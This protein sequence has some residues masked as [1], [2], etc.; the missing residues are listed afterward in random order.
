V[1][2]DSG[3]QLIGMSPKSQAS[4]KLLRLS[5]SERFEHPL[6]VPLRVENSGELSFIGPNL[7]RAWLHALFFKVGFLLS[8]INRPKLG[9]VSD[10]LRA[11]N[12]AGVTVCNRDRDR[13]SGFP[14]CLTL[15]CDP[16]SN[17]NFHRLILLCRS[18]PVWV[19]VSPLECSPIPQLVVKTVGTKSIPRCWHKSLY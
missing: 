8:Y 6:V 10:M 18:S 7:N 3:I 19:P 12:H 14:K 11:A 13:E 5:D 15:P 2:S 4:R 16:R 17:L 9:S 1:T